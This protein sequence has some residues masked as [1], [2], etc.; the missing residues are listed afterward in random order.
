[1]TPL[2]GIVISYSRPV[3]S[4]FKPVTSLIRLVISYSRLVISTFLVVTSL[5]CLIISIL[6]LSHVDILTCHIV[7]SSC[8]IDIRLVISIS[9]LAISLFRL[10]ISFSQHVISTFLVLIP[11]FRLDILGQVWYLIVSIPDLCNLTYF[12]DGDTLTCYLVISPCH[13]FISFLLSG[14]FDFE[15]CSS[16][17]VIRVLYK[18]DK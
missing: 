18:W 16:P 2:F 10:A 1:M 4:T 13:I 3:I 6:Y 5:F 11:L 9:R 17:N 15:F 12:Y 8:Y 14:K 7:V